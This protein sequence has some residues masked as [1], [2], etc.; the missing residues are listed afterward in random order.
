MERKPIIKFYLKGWFWMDL[1]S[2]FPY[3][4]LI[5]DPT[6]FESDGEMS[7]FRTNAQ[8]IR[9]FR[10]MRFFRCLRLLR[11]LKLQQL[12]NKIENYLNISLTVSILLGFSKLSMTILCIA[13]WIACFWHYF[14][15]HYI[16]IYDNTWL[17]Q[18]GIEDAN[19]AVR[20]I[21]SIYWATTTIITIGY[22]DI[23][24]VTQ[25]EKLFAISVM[26][27]G[28]GVFG[29][30]MNKMNNLLVQLDSSATNYR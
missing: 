23:V 2:S 10:I 22:G 3:T 18:V 30:V 8:I 16:G 29:F 25:E 26:V 1:L 12:V 5:S 17:T 7:N 11:I 6:N 24:P 28:C 13:H 4:W 21:N 19:L 14:G 27:V 15:F 9:I 20:Y